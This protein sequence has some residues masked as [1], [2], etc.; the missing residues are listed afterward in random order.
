MT[1]ARLSRQ[2]SAYLDGELTPADTDGVRAHLAQCAACRRELE[3]LQSVKAL[4]QRLPERPVPQDLWA[5]IRRQVDRPARP[6]A[7]P[8]GDRLRGTFR[9]PAVAWAV[10]VLVVALITGALVWGRLEQLR[11][12]GVGA[13]LFVREHALASAAEPFSDRAYLG[14]LIGD[15]SLALIG[16]PREEARE[17]R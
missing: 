6:F 14:L 12:A 15:A 2:L 13:D 5:S 3:H 16:V 4:L 9:R 1:H 10:A 7:A 11:A 17:E 8:L